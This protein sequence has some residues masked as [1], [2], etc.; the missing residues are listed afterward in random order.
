MLG[1]GGNR[2]RTLRQLTQEHVNVI[3]YWT[4]T[5][6]KNSTTVPQ[7]GHKQFTVFECTSSLLV[8]YY[9]THPEEPN[10]GFLL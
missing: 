3:N 5:N 4:N 1:D 6:N 2:Y 10:F 8:E 7:L 9:E